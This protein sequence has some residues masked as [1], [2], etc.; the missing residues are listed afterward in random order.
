MSYVYSPLLLLLFVS[1]SFCQ[2]PKPIKED[3]TNIPI[4]QDTH[5]A[6]SVIETMTLDEKIGQL[7]MVAG[8][9]NRDTAYENELSELISKY[10]I[11]GVIFFQGGPMRQVQITNRIQAES[12]IPLLVG[13]D[14]EW[15]LE[16]RLDST[17]AFPYQMALGAIQDDSLIYAMGAT[18]AHQ[19][20]RMGIHVNFAPVVDINNNPKNPVINYRSFG[21][22]KE[23]VVRKGIMYMNGLQDNH[24]IASAKHFPG[25]GDTDKDSHKTLPLILHDRERLD[26]IELYPFRELI[27]GGVKSIMVGHLNIPALDPKEN[28]A[29]S[30]SKPIVSDLLKKELGY[31]GLIIT[32][33]MNMKGVAD[34]YPPGEVDVQVL[35]AGNDMILMPVDVSKT[36]AAIKAAI[37]QGVLTPEDIDE[38][39]RKVLEAKQ[40]AKVDK[41][42]PIDTTHL[43]ADLNTPEAK[44]LKRKLLAAALTLLRNEDQLLPLQRLDTLKVAT[45]AIGLEKET[46]FQKTVEKYIDADHFFLPENSTKEMISLIEK[47][48]NNYNLLLISLHRK[49]RRPGTSVVLTPQMTAFLKKMATNQHVV[50]TLFRNAYLLNR[51][52][53]LS[54]SNAVLVTYQDGDVVGTLAA[55][56]IFGAIGINGK[57]PVSANSDFKA[58]DGLVTKGDFRL[59]YAPPE[60]VGINKEELLEIDTLAFAAIKEAAIPGCVVLVAKDGEVIYNKAFGYHTYDSVQQVQAD[61]IYDL[62]SITK[63]AAALPALMKLYAEG[64]FDLDDPISKYLKEFKKKDKRDITFREVLAHQGGLTAWI[65][66][67]KNTVKENGR[68]KWFTFKADSSKRFPYKV[69][70]HLYLNRNYHKKIYRAIRK[71]PVAAQPTYVYSDLSFYLY[72]Q[73]VEQ[74]SGV[75]FLQ[76]LEENFYAP[77][78]AETLTYNPYQQFPVA[79]IVP[80]EYD[81]LF[82]KGLIQGRVHDEGAA[83]LNGVS[84]HAGLFGNAN[85]LAKLMQMYLQN[86]WYNG[87]TYIDS[88][89]LAEFTGCQFCEEGN[90]RALGFDRP[91]EPYLENGNTAR[92]ASTESFGHSGF[93]GTFTWADPKYNLIYIFLSNR[94][95]PTRENVLLFTLNTRTKIQQ[96]IYNALHL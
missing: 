83:M 78:G 48:L 85:D 86:G 84:G 88:T 55:E 60:A 2:N 15:G 32:D 38:R 80:T 30:L 43:I 29:S 28:Q 53:G 75:P 24:I 18:L 89:T 76:Y 3:I 27:K 71:S 49:E 96:V 63:I 66:F 11:G 39:A 67:W 73:L 59:G 65:P 95:Y 22:E 70:E 17:M 14:G 6:D 40:W 82:R 7:I 37:E 72:P 90:R 16:M 45:I 61:D 21:E 87:H 51:Y 50:F 52:P 69:S 44:L 26:D 8:Y 13:I 94:V 41:F 31:E 10:K 47:Q 42:E 34:R 25:H 81:S 54:H 46:T 62:A 5:W 93:T 9:S 58:G 35:L 77:L 91:I 33:A 20:T 36:I 56:A 74:L 57:L 64:K 19:L 1:S 79:R 68:F 23:N 12:N 92:S 4:Q